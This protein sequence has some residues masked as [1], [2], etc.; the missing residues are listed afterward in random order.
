MFPAVV[1]AR[2]GPWLG[3]LVRSRP[4]LLAS[5]VA[6]LRSAGAVVGDK[7]DDVVKYFKSNPASASLALATIA[8]LGVSVADLFD[9]T[10]SQQT[11]EVAGLI[12]G[13]DEVA[14]HA[15]PEQRSAAAA[16]LLRYGAA[17]ETFKPG[18]V[19]KETDLLALAE[20]LKWAKA[21]YGSG[22][23][24]LRAHRLHQAFVELPYEE[25]RTGF[26]LLKV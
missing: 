7:L 19:E 16:S 1:V 26:A 22:D 21:H 25:V 17:S 9:G 10:D 20:T 4:G 2:F 11:A 5:V 18:L 15:T 13:L 23:A 3:S 14:S 8:S 24:A 12:R 6:K